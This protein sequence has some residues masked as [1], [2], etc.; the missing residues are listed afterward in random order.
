MERRS[1]K[2]IDSYTVFT[3]EKDN[4]RPRRRGGKAILKRG[5]EKWDVRVS[6]V[7]PAGPRQVHLGLSWNT[8]VDSSYIS[9]KFV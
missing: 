6:N 2:Y 9:K 5:F 4:L 7:F 1:E 3:M 8:L